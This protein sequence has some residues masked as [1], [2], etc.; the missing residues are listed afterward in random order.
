MRIPRASVAAACIALLCCGITIPFASAAL[1]DDWTPQ[2]TGL[3]Q[4]YAATP[5]WSDEFESGPITAGASLVTQPDASK[6]SKINAQPQWNGER[7]S[8]VDD[9]AHSAVSG[10]KLHIA[11]TR[12]V[13]SGGGF[14]SAQ[15]STIGK[16][17]FKY[18][19][20]AARVRMTRGTGL[21]PSIWL[22]GEDPQKYEEISMVE[23][24]ASGGSD[25]RAASVAWFSTGAGQK[26]VR[27]GLPA[28]LSVEPAA[29]ADDFHGQRAHLPHNA[30]RK[31]RT[32]LS[33]VN[34]L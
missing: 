12:N 27:A 34:S 4:S 9:A 13:G 18:G 19:L 11:V 2:D 22:F 26:A 1:A 23:L 30:L 6:W 5:T 28:A 29:F 15:I 25:G 17:S 32:R 10:G 24:G 33:R 31:R 3:S 8:Y 21:W 16:V 14:Q 7:Q 20:F